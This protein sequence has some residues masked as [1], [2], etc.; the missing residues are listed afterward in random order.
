MDWFDRCTTGAAKL[1]MW[2]GCTAVV[3]MAVHVTWDVVQRTFFGRGMLGTTEI[4]SFYYMV[5][6]VCFPL[7]WIERR[8]EHI[9]VEILFQ[10][11][12]S[13]IQRV[14]TLFATICSAGFFSAFAYRSWLDALNALSTG[15]T[16][17][18]YAEI[19]IWPARFI[20]PISFALVV[21]VCVSQIVRLIFRYAPPAADRP[22]EEDATFRA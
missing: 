1:L 13:G 11:M 19:A 20:L 6:V 12:S 21:V 10:R 5:A 18:G 9:N 16:M 2:V 4:V 7:A 22:I 14:M 17:M 15:E 8:D 3:L